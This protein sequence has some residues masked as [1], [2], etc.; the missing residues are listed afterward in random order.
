MD[1]QCL[2]GPQSLLELAI[3]DPIAAYAYLRRSRR[4][5]FSANCSFPFDAATVGIPIISAL[6]TQI[7]TRTWI[8]NIAVSVQQPN[9]FP[10]NVF[11]TEY[12]ENLKR[13]T[14]V[15]VKIQVSSGPRYVES[16]NFTPLENIAQVW[17]ARWPKGWRIDRLQTVAIEAM[18]TQLPA[19]TPYLV[20]V[21]F[22][23]WQY[24]DPELDR[25]TTAEAICALE[26]AG[27]CIPQLVC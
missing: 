8:D 2:Q 24:A 27:L 9:S 6:D 1:P 16:L 13:N 17:A 21:T 20:V 19:S 14:G 4:L 3:E 12:L 25:V 23:G 15:N 5:P 18:L 10:G 22:N 11:Y 7:D 26:K